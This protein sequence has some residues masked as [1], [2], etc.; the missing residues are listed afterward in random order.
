MAAGLRVVGQVGTGVLFGALWLVTRS[1]YYAFMGGEWLL[2][3][4]KD[5][6]ND[7]QRW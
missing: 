5:T 6:Y 4:L 3:G 2:G 7:L 1:L